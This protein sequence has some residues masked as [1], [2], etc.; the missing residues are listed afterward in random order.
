MNAISI[1]D[2]VGVFNVGQ[3]SSDYV[4]AIVDNLIDIHSE[5][6]LISAFGRSLYDHYK[7][8]STD[9]MY[10]EIN[11]ILNGTSSPIVAYIYF[12]YLKES[13][14]FATGTGQKRLL[15]AN[16]DSTPVAYKAVSTWNFVNK[17]T[18]DIR[19][20]IYNSVDIR[21]YANPSEM[22]LDLISRLNPH[23]L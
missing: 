3:K 19:I 7:D 6:Y 4:Q 13:Q 8:N 21:P 1:S 22:C 17:G 11:D 14:S 2:F 9:S 10:D 5:E 18:R 15:G 23:D 20:A 16:S 12:H